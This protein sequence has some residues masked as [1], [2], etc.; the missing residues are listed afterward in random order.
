MGKYAYNNNSKHS[1]MN[2]S[3]FY[4]NYGFQPQTNWPT[5]IQFK[6][7]AS[8]LYGHYMNS[9]HTKLSTQWEY[10]IEA[11]WKYYDKK[12]KSIEPI[13]KGELVMLN[14]RNIR[15]KHHCKKLEDKMYGLFE[16]GATGK[17]RR[18]GKVKL[19]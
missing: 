13:K 8:Q 15:A 4:A 7:P 11:M 9:V 2:I 6:N 18:Y 16:V 10:S 3:P 12:Q 14:G 17:N 1:A 19:P 5:E